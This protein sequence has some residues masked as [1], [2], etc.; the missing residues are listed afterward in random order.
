[1]FA[2]G[3]GWWFSIFRP[4]PKRKSARSSEFQAPRDG[5]EPL[6]DGNP[7]RISSEHTVKDAYLLMKMAKTGATRTNQM[8]CLV[9]SPKTKMEAQNYWPVE[10]VFTMDDLSF[11]KWHFQVP[12][13]FS[14]GISWWTLTKGH[15]CH[16]QRR[17]ERKLAWQG[18]EGYGCQLTV[19]CLQ[20]MFVSLI[21]LQPSLLPKI[22]Q[23]NFS[24]L[25]ASTETLSLQSPLVQQHCALSSHEPYTYRYNWEHIVGW[26]WQ[27][28][29]SAVAAFL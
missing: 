5:S 21:V 15:L 1:M 14:A 10:T 29:C 17:A 7:L 23:P 20:N 24:W 3:L 25:L 4:I 27:C 2:G 11:P 26:C 28:F 13:E 22:K 12:C 16:G 19:W 6:V 8:C 18:E 9:K